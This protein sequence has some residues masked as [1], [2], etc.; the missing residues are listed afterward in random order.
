MT[1]SL[2]EYTTHSVY[3]TYRG[4]NMSKSLRK[5]ITMKQEDYEL[6]KE[7]AKKRH[8]SFSEFLCSSAL[9]RIENDSKLSL[10]EYL[11]KYTPLA[12]KEESEEIAKILE[13]FDEDYED[14]EELTIEDVLRGNI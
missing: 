4:S 2:I 3:N 11:D 8:M 12:S 13:N 6:I 1:T 10:G 14:F 9:Q 5:N 7:N